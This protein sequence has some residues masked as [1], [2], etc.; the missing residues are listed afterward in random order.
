MAHAR[1]RPRPRRRRAGRAPP[2]GRRA[3][4][5]LRLLRLLRPQDLRTHRHRRPLRQDR[6]P[7]GHAPLPGRRRHDPAPSPSR[8]PPTTSCPTSS[9]RARRTSRASSAWARPSTTWSGLGL[10]AI[11]AHEHDL[12]EYGTRTAAGG[13]GRAPDRH[14][15]REGRRRSPSC[16]RA[17]T[18]TTSAP[19]STTRGS[20]SAP[21][22]TA[23]SR[24]WS[25]TACPPPRGPRWP[26]YNTRAGDRRAGGRAAQGAR[27]LPVISELRE[28]YQEMIL[29]HSR[30]AAQL[31][32]R[33][34]PPTA[35]P[36]ATTRCAATGRRSPW[37][38]TGTSSRTSASRAQAA[39]S[40]PP[41]PRM[42]T[43]SVKGKTRQ[44][45]RGP[46][47]AVPRSH[48]Q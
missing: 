22:T 2:D 43:E 14:R 44:R 36:R 3:G 40:S 8:R 1:G 32:R 18:P 20:P 31:R 17:S 29:D 16:W 10:E 38:W 37:P 47:R 12:L 4:P 21:A 11:A 30:Q 45:D 46:V 35:G 42:M 25:A 19:S 24:S 28:L 39:R 41:P 13:P 15:A 34:P 7:R 33:C 23:P 5:G 9:R 6:A 48:H 26:L 27:G